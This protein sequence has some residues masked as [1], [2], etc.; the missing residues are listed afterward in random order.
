MPVTLG[1]L[2][3]TILTEVVITPGR[4][5]RQIRSEARRAVPRNLVRRLHRP[6]DR[7]P[8]P[9]EAQDVGVAS[10]TQRTS[11]HLSGPVLTKILPLA[12]ALHPL[13]ASGLHGFE[14]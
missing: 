2:R 1:T 7:R 10:G 12:S 3:L 6:R 13:G 11:A 9:H 5:R 4:R 14:A 8:G